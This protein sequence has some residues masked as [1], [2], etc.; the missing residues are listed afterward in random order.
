VNT[1]GENVLPNSSF[2]RVGL[3][4]VNAPTVAWLAPEER[5]CV[6]RRARLTVVAGSPARIRSVRF[7]DG[8]RTIA[9]VR[10]GAAGLYSATWPTARAKSGTHRLRA[11]VVDA[12]G[13]EASATRPVRVCR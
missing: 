8:T 9:T 12:K 2:L 6:E 1:A 3:R 4:V 13:R 5:E 7:L 10:R 11:V